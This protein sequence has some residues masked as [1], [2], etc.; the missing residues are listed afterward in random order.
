MTHRLRTTIAGILAFAVPFA[1]Y[2]ASLRPGL[3]FWDT[4]ELQTVP[5]ILGI[6]H[7]T[8]FPAYVLIGWMWSHVLPFGDPAYRMNLLSAAGMATACGAVAGALREWDVEP[9]FALG[10][11]LVFAFTRVPWDHGTHADV[12]AL[13][14]GVAG[15]AF[16]AALRWRRNGSR[17]A[18]YACALLCGLAL[19]IHSAMV[20]LVPGV[21]LAALARRPAARQI[22]AALALGA[23]LVVGAYAYLPLRSAVVYAE[24]KDPTL[25][26]GVAPGRPFW[27]NDHPST[28]AGF[29]AEI[30]GSE[31]G[32]GHALGSLFDPAVVRS[33]PSRFGAAALGDLAGGVLLI[34]FVGAIAFVRRSPFGGT[35]LLLGGFLPVLFVLAYHAESDPERY[36]LAS[37]WVIAVFLGAGAHVLGLGGAER[38]PRGVIAL[39]GTLFV[40]VAAA[41][42]YANRNAFGAH[43]DEARRFVT[44]VIAQ[45]PANSIIVAPWMYATP[46]AYGAYVEHRLGDR[47]VVTGWPRDYSGRYREWL[48][49][50]PV[51]IVGEEQ[52]PVNAGITWRDD[53]PYGARPALLRAQAAR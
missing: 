26:L 4:G 21:A 32:A 43:D 46:L 18:L 49:R 28:F 53:D 36:F 2:V 35:G 40:F 16:W 50:R 42:V 45:T 20:L 12:H 11:A 34:A 38:A 29:R 10:A 19:A 33:L 7:P 48:A 8:G 30:A 25:A 13:A 3:D 24:R 51:R 6:P 37:Y 23:V 27:D 44:R 31:F 15:L 39:V 1:A 9:V 5:Y 14:I 22:G 41:N 52:L 17:R 47:I